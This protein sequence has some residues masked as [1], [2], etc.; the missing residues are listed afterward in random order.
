MKTR[1]TSFLVLVILCAFLLLAAKS[2]AQ[3]VFP[4]SGNVGIGTNTPYSLLHVN[5][6]SG[7]LSS[8][9]GAGF[10]FQSRNDPST[11]WDWYGSGNNAHFGITNSVNNG[12]FIFT[13]YTEK[14]RIG[15]RGISIG[16]AFFPGVNDFVLHDPRYSL[17]V[18]GTIYASQDIY[19]QRK[20]G[21]GTTAPEHNLHVNGNE[22]LSTGTQSG[23]KFRNRNSTSSAED[24]VW[25]ADQ[26]IA[27]LWQANRGDLLVVTPA[28]NVG[29]GTATPDPAYKLSV[30]GSIRAKSIRV[31]TG[32][33]DYVFNKAYRLK[34]LAEVE[35]FIQHHQHLPDVPSAAEVEQNGVNLGEMEAVLL[36]KIEELTLYVIEQDKAIRKLTQE[37]QAIR[38][39]VKE[40]EPVK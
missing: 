32:W 5:G 21:V 36:R 40:A 4:A 9:S 30:N 34:P 24:W 28:G 23:F 20:L 38:H 39:P 27:R 11:G 15:T 1:L 7:V 14:M 35:T 18:A 6:T 12:F 17:D 19:A 13:S 2:H 3:N 33:A 25:Y 8:G 31:N 37:N 10:T 29:M 26:N 22:I 16:S